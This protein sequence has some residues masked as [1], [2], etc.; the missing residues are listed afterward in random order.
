M[1]NEMEWEASKYDTL[2]MSYDDIKNFLFWFYHWK[3]KDFFTQNEPQKCVEAMSLPNL[4]C[5]KGGDNE[6]ENFNPR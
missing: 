3:I 6:L 1:S 2:L 5:E 4:I